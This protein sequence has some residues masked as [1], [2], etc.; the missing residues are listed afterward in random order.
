MR[1][2]TWKVRSLYRAGSLTAAARELAR[3]K[4]DLVDVQEVRRDRGGIV[5]AGDY[6]FY[7]KGNENHQLGTGFIVHHGIILAVTRAQFVSIRVSYIVLRVCCYNIIVLN[8][9]RN[10]S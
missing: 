9:H 8:V 5:R 6:V 10:V 1:I 2:G 4:L 7:G 3:Y